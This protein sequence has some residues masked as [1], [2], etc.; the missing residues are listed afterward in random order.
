MNTTSTTLILPAQ[1]QDLRDKWGTKVARNAA[2]LEALRGG[3]KGAE[4][5]RSFGIS[6]E[7][8]RQVW[9]RATQE[10]L[11][12]RGQWCGYCSARFPISLATR[13]GDISTHHASAAHRTVMLE[14]RRIR[15]ARRVPHFWDQVD[16]T[17]S[18]WTWR[19]PLDPSGYGRGFLMPGTG[20]YA[21]RMAYVLING[22]IP[23]G[24]TLD[25]LCRNRACVNPDHL[26]AVT[27]RENILRS[28]VAVA[29][30]NARKTHCKQG[31]PYD[32]ANTVRNEK[33]HRTCRTCR[34]ASSRAYQR[35]GRRR[36]VAVA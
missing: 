7:R 12:P 34:N 27:L 16:K 15:E 22:P 10:G 21:H 25:H 13:T 24:L 29:A 3:A 2:I 9:T 23:S 4:V 30:I 20:G 1:A 11:R 35:S 19:G 31:H 28:P 33:G 32:E 14:R 26:E 17:D 36:K 6:R 5:A 8:V 18:C